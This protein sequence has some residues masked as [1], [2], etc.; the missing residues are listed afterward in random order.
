MQQKEILGE[1]SPSLGFRT[2]G[3]VC[4][5]RVQFNFTKFWSEKG[6]LLSSLFG[7]QTLKD[8]SWSFYS[9]NLTRHDQ[10]STEAVSTQ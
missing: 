6:V 3:P 4:T 2:E 8:H 9:D 1:R 5:V 10:T 7:F